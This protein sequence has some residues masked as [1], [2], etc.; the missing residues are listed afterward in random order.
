M[1]IELILGYLIIIGI[2]AVGW[3][4]YLREK[5][6][7]FL[8]EHS[9]KLKGKVLDRWASGKYADTDIYIETT[10]GR[11]VRVGPQSSV[12][13]GDGDNRIRSLQDPQFEFSSPVMEH[14][15]TGYKDLYGSWEGLKVKARLL[16]EDF[17]D[18][19]RDI[20]E[21]VRIQTNLTPYFN[22]GPEPHSFISLDVVTYVIFGEIES[23]VSHGGERIFGKAEIAPQNDKFVLKCSSFHCLA[24]SKNKD[25]IEECVQVMRMIIGKKDM[26]ERTGRLLS[27]R[28]KFDNEH[29][30]ILSSIDEISKSIEMGRPIRG[31]CRYCRRLR[32][33]KPIIKGSTVQN[34]VGII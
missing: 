24:K 19:I 1:M 25:D 15:S 13:F 33:G 30:R 10:G 28:D 18:L 12:I 20:R 2:A 21:K 9:G 5:R 3:A 7:G 26:R 8:M 32:K 31:K 27:R 22:K 17:S 11:S 34:R 16:A 6:F 29:I 14:F 4:L 23:S